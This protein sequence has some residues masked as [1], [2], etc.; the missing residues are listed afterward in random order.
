MITLTAEN[1]ILALKEFL[2]VWANQILYYNEIYSPE[3]FEKYKSFGVIIFKSRNPAV[4]SYLEKF[5]NS[6]IEILLTDY[7][8]K[9]RQLVM[10]VYDSKSN[11][12]R[13]KYV[14]QFNDLINLSTA[15]PDL[16][17][18]TTENPTS[19]TKIDISTLSWDEVYTQL[20]SALFQHLNEL[21]RKSL[22][23]KKSDDLFFKT[24]IEIDDSFNLDALPLKSEWV[25]ISNSLKGNKTPVKGFAPIGEV[26]LA[27][28]NFDLHNEYIS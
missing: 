26:S 2:V 8:G 4:N 14:I 13:H 1:L 17:F 3:I 19:E 25:R 9:V 5:V 28:F 7:G 6:F 24:I 12:A 21:R 18:L 16:S 10:L 15:L 27:V 11:Y 22:S 20:R 23:I